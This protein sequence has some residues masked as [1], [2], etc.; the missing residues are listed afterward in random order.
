MEKFQRAKE[1]L[2]DLESHDSPS[3]SSEEE[4]MSQ[5][6]ESLQSIRRNT[7]HLG[8]SSDNDNDNDNGGSMIRTSMRYNNKF[9]KV[10]LRTL[11]QS[12]SDISRLIESL[13]TLVSHRNVN[14]NDDNDDDNDDNEE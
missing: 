3:D 1:G 14:Y 6:L 4:Q 10:T 13:S 11:L 12:K 7:G 5:L 9:E 8:E 2:L